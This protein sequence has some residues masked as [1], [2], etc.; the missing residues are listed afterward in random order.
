MKKSP[1]TNPL[2]NEL[3]SDLKK[4]AY[5][6]KAPIW[7]DIAKRLEKPSRNWAEVNLSHVSKHANKGD[8]VIVPGKLLGM[9]NID[10]AVTVA[11]FSFSKSA[12]IKLKKAG[13]KNLTIK[14]LIRKNP[15]GKN[16]KILG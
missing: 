7:K 16:I 5:K 2:L 15:K 8:T 6:N 1:K 3:I 14:E 10:K 12:V 13:G 11:A 4:S 9:G